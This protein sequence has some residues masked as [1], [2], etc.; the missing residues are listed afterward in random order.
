MNVS[1][2]LLHQPCVHSREALARVHAAAWAA[3]LLCFGVGYACAAVRAIPQPAVFSAAVAAA[4]PPPPLSC[5]SASSPLRAGTSATPPR[6]HRP[7]AS[8][9]AAVAQ[10]KSRS[11][12]RG[13]QSQLRGGEQEER[14][15]AAGRGAAAGALE[16]PL[17]SWREG[18]AAEQDD[19]PAAVDVQG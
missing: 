15:A 10:G 1:G 16:Q 7:R 2:G 5:P 13:L 6:R 9:G 12:P 18:A 3:T 8:L 14:R 17:L 11:D 4:P 19:R